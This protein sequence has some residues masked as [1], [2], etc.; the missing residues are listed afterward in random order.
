MSDLERWQKQLKE[1]MVIL[2]KLWKSLDDLWENVPNTLYS[3]IYDRVDKFYQSYWDVFHGAVEVQSLEELSKA[4]DQPISE[5]AEHV[6]EAWRTVAFTKVEQLEADIEDAHKRGPTQ[7][8]ETR[9]GLKEAK[10]HLE[11]GTKQTAAGKHFEATGSFKNC[12]TKCD[13]TIDRVDDAI[14]AMQ[15]QLQEARKQQI[16]INLSWL[17]L[18]VAIIG[19]IIIVFG[20]LRF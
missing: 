4:L 13:T 15:I 9:A 20:I 19:I 17:Q 12:I 11:E 8:A 7:L 2:D 6:V 16:T 18:L 5:A 10:T 3:Q 1:K 14:S